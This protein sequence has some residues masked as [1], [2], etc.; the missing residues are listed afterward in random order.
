MYNDS[1]AFAITLWLPRANLVVIS[2]RQCG[3]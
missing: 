3:I 1:V 2:L